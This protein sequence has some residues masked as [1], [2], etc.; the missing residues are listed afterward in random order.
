MHFR[1][2]LICLA[3]WTI[4]MTYID[5]EANICVDAL[6]LRK[7]EVDFCLLVLNAVTASNSLLL[8]RGVHVNLVSCRSPVCTRILS[9]SL[10][11]LSSEDFFSKSDSK[12]EQV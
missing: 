10:T 11:Y 6:A 1:M 3:V 7:H 9:F 5:R 4:E 2:H 12:S 8:T